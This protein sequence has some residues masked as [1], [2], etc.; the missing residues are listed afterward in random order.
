MSLRS[1][2]WRAVAA[3]F[4]ALNL[5]GAVYAIARGEILHAGIHV[6]LLLLVGAYLMRQLAP[7]R[8]DAISASSREFVDRL[9]SLEQSV[10]A[11][12][13]E[14]ERMGEGQRF[15]TRVFAEPGT[16]RATEPV[17]IEAQQAAPHAGRE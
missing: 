11:V 15:I 16:P 9:A 6:G 3:L 10:D 1:M 2:A 13:I 8:A 7:R 14:V 5:G 17:G 4:L 12:A